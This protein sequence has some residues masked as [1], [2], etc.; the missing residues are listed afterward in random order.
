MASLDSDVRRMTSI[1]ERFSE[2]QKYVADV[3]FLRAAVSRPG[4]D[5]SGLH[6]VADAARA[7]LKA[8]AAAELN[9]KKQPTLLA[10]KPFP[11]DAVLEE[12]QDLAAQVNDLD[13]TVNRSD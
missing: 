4:R 6:G 3:G 2:A 13:R 12:I 1:E 10:T 7:L 9:E 8:L 11:L 5:H